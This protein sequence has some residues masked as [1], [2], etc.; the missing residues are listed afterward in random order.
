MGM[1]VGMLKWE[2]WPER[3]KGGVKF[4]NIEEAKE[5]NHEMDR[6]AHEAGLFGRAKATTISPVCGPAALLLKV[7]ITMNNSRVLEYRIPQ[8]ALYNKIKEKCGDEVAQL[9][10]CRN[11]CLTALETVRQHQGVEAVINM[12]KATATDGHCEF[13]MRRV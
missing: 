2:R 8:C 9:M 13:S 7:P 1:G 3:Y 12:A 4:V 10:T 5:W 6:R 11:Y